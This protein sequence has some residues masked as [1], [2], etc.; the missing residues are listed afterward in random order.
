MKVLSIV[1]VLLALTVGVVM[2]AGWDG[3]DSFYKNST[4]GIVKGTP[5]NQG[6]ISALTTMMGALLCRT[7][8][9]TMGYCSPFT[10]TTGTC[11]CN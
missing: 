8:A 9:G 3:N 7:S 11:T 5:I 10:S 2:A 1:L 4:G 6:T